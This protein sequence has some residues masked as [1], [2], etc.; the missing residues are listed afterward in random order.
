MAIQSQNPARLVKVGVFYDGN[1]FL[2]VS[3][4]YSYEH[5]RQARI[6]IGGLHGFIKNQVS[7]LEGLDPDY[8]H[9]VDAHFFRGR[10]NAVEARDQ[11]KLFNDRIFDDILMNEGVVTHYLPIRSR[12]G[13]REEKGIDVWLALEA[14]E[15][16][17]YKHFDVVVLI[18]C[19]GDYVPL[20]RKLN[21]MGVR[22]MLLSWDFKFTD[23]FG[24]E[25]ETRTS[26]DLLEE[27][28]Y[29]VI[30]HNIIDNRLANKNGVIDKLFVSQETKKF[31]DNF[32]QRPPAASA[33]PEGDRLVSV[34]T[35]LRPGYGFIAAKPQNLFFS[36]ADLIEGEFTDLREGDTIEFSIGNNEKGEKAD[37]VRKITNYDPNVTA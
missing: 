8:C 11:N 37:A 30:M 36:Y 17:M 5:E 19:D 7:E 32:T 4:Y 22:V 15:L 28:T 13:K 27:A 6:S 25:R 29:P 9:V 2:K 35:T 21:T 18:A 23:D 34:I 24:Q 14:F 20:V 1:Y 26:Q 31:Y 10:L 16:T 3:N 33:I 12:Y